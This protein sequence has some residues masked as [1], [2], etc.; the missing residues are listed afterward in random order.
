MLTFKGPSVIDIAAEW[1]RASTHVLI[2]AGAGL[3]VAAGIDYT[4]S[5]SFAELYPATRRRG[6]RACYELIGRHDLPPPVFWG[7]WG[8]HVQHVRFA[9][10]VAAVYEALRQLTKNK[11][12]F[13]VTSNV[14]AIFVRNGFEADGVWT[15][16]GDF[17]HMH[18]TARRLP[19]CARL[20]WSSEPV[21]E[22]LL[23]HLDPTTHEVDAPGLLV[24]RR[25]EAVSSSTFVRMR[26]SS[27]A[28]TS[29]RASDVSS[30]YSRQWTVH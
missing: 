4:D 2:G 16:Q 29:T 21:L 18:C 24:A 8:V 30:G 25:A 26:P 12:V 22:R 27:R 28:R 23:Q 17:A 19:E 11:D 15:P 3:S 10:G 6:F 14:E 9:P 20:V 7:Y 13:V 1:L 5:E